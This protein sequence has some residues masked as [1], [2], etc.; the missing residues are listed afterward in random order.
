MRDRSFSCSGWCGVGLIVLALLSS[1]CGPPQPHPRG[2][3]GAVP[4]TPPARM[5]AGPTS[6]GCRS[7]EE[8][9]RRMREPDLQI[10]QA[11][12]AS[13]GVQGAAVIT[14][15][16]PDGTL[17]D[18]KWR[19]L[20]SESHFND[21]SAELAVV[22]LQDM[23][24]AP[25]DAVV[26]PTE[27]HCFDVEPYGALRHAVEP[28][29]ETRCVLGFLSYWL[30]GVVGLGALRRDGLL[31]SADGRPAGDPWLFERRRF[32]QNETYRRNV[33]NLNVIAYL[34]AHGDAHAGQFVGYR[35]PLHIFLVDSSVAFEMG[36]RGAMDDRQDLSTLVVPA[37]PRDTAA[38]LRALDRPALDRLAV[39]TTLAREGQSLVVVEDGP[40]FGDPDERLRVEGGRVQIGLTTE[41]IEGVQERVGVLRDRL[42][43]GSLRIFE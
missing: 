32:D 37:I 11:A 5:C 17:F 15:R 9:A 8:I 21:P 30:S 6:E 34:V 31:P 35:E 39:L 13:G 22:R 7:A 3:L 29:P 40:L 16:A 33:A 12:R 2:S 24:L 26:P 27:A 18:A 10:V 38:R 25:G 28:F 43:D 19:A 14:L 41:E 36:H 1:E 4:V 23:I 20:A 42:R